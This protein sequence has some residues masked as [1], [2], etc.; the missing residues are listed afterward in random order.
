MEGR[1]GLVHVGE[2]ASAPTWGCVLIYDVIE[3][4][5]TSSKG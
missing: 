5:V 2:E 3:R 4:R 1:V